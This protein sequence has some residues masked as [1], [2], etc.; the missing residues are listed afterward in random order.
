MERELTRAE[1]LFFIERTIAAT[2]R[3]NLIEQVRDFINE[4]YRADDPEGMAMELEEFFA[5]ALKGTGWRF[6]RLDLERGELTEEDE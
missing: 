4:E 1:K 5:D 6:D 2:H 3:A